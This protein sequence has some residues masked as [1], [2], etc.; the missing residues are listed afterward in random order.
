MTVQLVYAT[1]PDEASA[2]ELGE[3]VLEQRLAACFTHWEA[4]TRYW[5][6]EGI[7]VDEETLV[8]FKTTPE[9]TEDLVAYLVPC[10]LPLDSEGG[11]PTYEDWLRAETA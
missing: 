5:W 9:H 1:F 2:T 8:L 7:E 10:V 4:G 3:A 11:P 6:D